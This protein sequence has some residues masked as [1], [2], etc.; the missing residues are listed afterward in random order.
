[1]FEIDPTIK[2]SDRDEFNR[3][4]IAE[5]IINLFESDAAVSPL[6]LDGTWGSG[7]SEFCIKLINLAIEKKSEAKFIYVNSYQFDHSDDPMVLLASLISKEMPDEAKAVDLFKKA[8]PVI[9][10]IGKITGKITGKTVI[11]HALKINADKVQEQL[12]EAILET[13]NDVLDDSLNRVFKDYEKIEENLKV[14]KKALAK[15][16]EKSPMVIIVDELD[17]CRPQ[18]SL[19]LLE[20]LKHVFNV[21]GVRFLLSTNLEQLEV[22]VRNEYGDAISSKNYLEKFYQYIVRLPKSVKQQEVEEN[23]Y[24]L[25]QNLLDQHELLR[26]FC[27]RDSYIMSLFRYIF[28]VHHRSLRDTYRFVNNLKIYNAVAEIN[29]K[30]GNNTKWSYVM[31]YMVSTYIYTFN[32]KLA[33]GILNGNYTYDEISEFFMMTKNDILVDSQNFAHE[34]Y[35]ILVMELI[36]FDKHIDQYSDKMKDVDRHLA[37]L[38]SSPPVGRGH[39]LSIFQ[40]PIKTLQFIK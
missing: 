14:F 5:K 10:V 13:T 30:I 32:G 7:K 1:M 28:G 38:F 35:A 36:D 39:R 18:Y 15:I 12:S 33:I 3:R 20:K 2:F 25:L 4:M 23:S 16:A 17:R 19:N 27:T 6:V 37:R 24:I 31:A 8:I 34:V 9:K 26:Q 21:P 11:A 40:Q 29:M 22:S